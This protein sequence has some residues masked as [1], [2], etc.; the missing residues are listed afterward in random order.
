MFLCEIRYG[1]TSSK[2]LLIYSLSKLVCI[3]IISSV[4]VFISLWCCFGFIFILICE[5]TVSNVRFIAGSNLKLK[6]KSLREKAWSFY[7]WICCDKTHFGASFPQPIC[8][9]ISEFC[10]LNIGWSVDK[11]FVE[12]SRLLCWWF[13]VGLC[14][15]LMW[16]SEIQKLSPVAWGLLSSTSVLQSEASI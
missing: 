6:Q 8:Y 4:D 10:R 15:D 13:A 14:L 16:Q 9:Q 5:I 1:A 11:K 12:A 2:L 3:E 7:L